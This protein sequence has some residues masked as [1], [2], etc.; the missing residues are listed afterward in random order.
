MCVLNK[1][2]ILMVDFNAR[3]QD[4]Q[5]FLKE[6]EFFS[7]NFD[8]DNDL[9]DLF[10]NSSVLDKCYLPNIRTSQDKIINYEGNM[11]IDLCKA[12][13]LFILN[14]R[15]GGDKGIGAMTFCNQSIIDNPIISHQALRFVKMFSI[16]ELDSLFSD[17]HSLI[18][19]TLSFSKELAPT[20][21]KKNKSRKKRPKLPA[22][23]TAVL[24]KIWI[25]LKFLTKNNIKDA[26]NNLN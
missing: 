16:L 17:G 11:L 26:S 3:T 12:N 4:K 21:N 24:F 10:Q 7:Q 23:K 14:S 18:T 8:Y 2:V 22:S 15:C 9:I 13:S 6:D 25:I 5:D 20:K 1:Y 19:T